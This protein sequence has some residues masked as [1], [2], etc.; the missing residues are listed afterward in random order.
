MSVELLDVGSVFPNPN[1]PRKFFDPLALSELADS[2][3]INGLL[4]PIK[5]QRQGPVRFMIV[6]G[7]RRWR[8]HRLAELATIA[9]LV[10]DELEAGRL[11]DEAIIENLQRK[12]ITPLEEA[13][14]FRARL[15]TA[16]DA[17]RRAGAERAAKWHEKKIEQM[18]A[19]SA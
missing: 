11:A 16:A 2:I 6:C 5:V 9:A 7:E 14:A 12:D 17:H 1:Q 3:R 8:A 19:K 10:V 13:R 18:T 4:Q 15:D